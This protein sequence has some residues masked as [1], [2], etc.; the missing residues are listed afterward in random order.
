MHHPEDFAE[1]VKMDKL[2]RNGVKG[3]KNNKLF[4]HTSCKPLDEI[5]F[6]NDL[7]KGQL[8]FWEENPMQLE[9][10]GMCGL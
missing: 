3:T 8:D 10:Q 9:C 6:R 5:D 1:A 7:D 4:L 2:V